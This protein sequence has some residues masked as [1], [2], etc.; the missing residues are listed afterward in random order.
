MVVK[1]DTIDDGGVSMVSSSSSSS[2][3]GPGYGYG[4]KMGGVDQRGAV[5]M[6]QKGMGNGQP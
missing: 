5:G 3:H 4:A 6:D 2:R 1:V